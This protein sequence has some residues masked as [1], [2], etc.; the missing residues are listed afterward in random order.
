MKSR[1]GKTDTLC[2]LFRLFALWAALCANSPCGLRHALAAG[3][4]QTSQRKPAA[5][6]FSYPLI[7]DCFCCDGY[8]EK[9]S[10]HIS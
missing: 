6:C 3:A 9:T 5:V 7:H 1:D 10:G 2:F 4:L 8:N